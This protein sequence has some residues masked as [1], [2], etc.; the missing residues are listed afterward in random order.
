[1]KCLVGELPVHGF[2]DQRL[3]PSY[4]SYIVS[5]GVV[6][7]LEDKTGFRSPYGTLTLNIYNTK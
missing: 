5:S 1:M 7:C 6:P 4:R 2:Q 3:M